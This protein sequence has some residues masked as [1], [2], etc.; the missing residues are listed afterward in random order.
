MGVASREVVLT[1][2]ES[3]TVPEPLAP[4]ILPPSENTYSTCEGEEVE[5]N[6]NSHKIASCH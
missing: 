6:C 3:D 1:D 2:I 5:K 4:D